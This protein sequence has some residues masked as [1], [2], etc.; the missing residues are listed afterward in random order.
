MIKIQIPKNQFWHIM[1]LPAFSEIDENLVINLAT[2]LVFL[3]IYLWHI[4]HDH[5][6]RNEQTRHNEAL[7]NEVRAIKDEIRKLTKN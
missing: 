4:R 5:S 3:G 1:Y 2:I 6:H 7:L